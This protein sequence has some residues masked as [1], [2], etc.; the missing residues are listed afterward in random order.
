VRAAEEDTVEGAP[1]SST[2]AT[3]A[4]PPAAAGEKKD[5]TWEMLCHLSAL[6]G[7]IGV[8]FGNILGPLIV[9]QVKKN[10]VPALEQHGKEALN[11]HISLLIYG[12]VAGVLVFVIIGIPLLILI[13]LGGIVCSIIGAVRANDGGFY[14]YPMTIRML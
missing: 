12:A 1:G 13:W 8:P 3:P 10:E 14:R 5:H 9:W 2:A 4:V 11:F 7:L 6:S